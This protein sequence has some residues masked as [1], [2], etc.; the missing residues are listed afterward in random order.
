MTVWILPRPAPVSSI[1]YEIIEQGKEA[2]RDYVKEEIRKLRRIGTKRMTFAFPEMRRF[3]Y[4][5]ELY[6]LL[7]K[8]S[9]K[10]IKRLRKIRTIERIIN[11]N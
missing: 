1:P 2:I 4:Q 10:Q 11:E 5:D 3:L 7:D 6:R 9:M 8:R